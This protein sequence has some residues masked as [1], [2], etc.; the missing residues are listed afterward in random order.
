M[1]RFFYSYNFLFQGPGCALGL[2][3]LFI[4]Y[5]N[6]TGS[7]VF[8]SSEVGNTIVIFSHFEAK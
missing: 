7:C 5:V 1:V 2:C 4:A 3:A 6:P 8:L